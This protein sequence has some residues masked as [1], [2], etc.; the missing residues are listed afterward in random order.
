[1]EKR[2]HTKTLIISSMMAALIFAI[3]Y[4]IRIPIQFYSKVC[5]INLGDSIIYCAGILVGAPWAAAAA[6]IGSALADFIAGV[7]VYIPATLVIKA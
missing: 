6:G 4:W 7:H 3:T 1:M 5:N 2:N